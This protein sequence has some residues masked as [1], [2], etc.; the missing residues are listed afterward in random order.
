MIWYVSFVNF[1]FILYLFMLLSMKEGLCDNLVL[2]FCHM[3]LVYDCIK[4]FGICVR[5]MD[6]V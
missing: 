4:I 6:G 1:N 5:K 2:I 3:V